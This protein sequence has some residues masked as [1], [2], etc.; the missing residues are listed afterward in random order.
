MRDV[1]LRLSK[2]GAVLNTGV[3]SA[4]CRLVVATRNQPRCGLRLVAHLW[5]H[6]EMSMAC[7]ALTASSSTKRRIAKRCEAEA[8]SKA[9]TVMVST[10]LSLSAHEAPVTAL[11]PPVS[12][13]R[14]ARARAPPDR[15]AV[16]SAIR[17]PYRS[18]R[19]VVGRR[20]VK[21]PFLGRH[22]VPLSQ[23]PKGPRL[24]RND[25]LAESWVA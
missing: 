2:D 17:A 16:E 9:L 18:H 3:S 11:L 13:S 10:L 19:H 25:D 24:G 23:R 12:P 1:A 7:P 20:C 21:T 4:W 5:T 14:P 6:N 22:H 15:S 8:A